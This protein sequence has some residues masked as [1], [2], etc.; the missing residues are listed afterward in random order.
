M[1]LRRPTNH[2]DA[3]VRGMLAIRALA[4]LA[5]A[6]VACGLVLS[7]SP[8]SAGAFVY[9]AS[10]RGQDRI[11]RANL[12]GTGAQTLIPTSGACAV[13]VDASHVYWATNG[14]LFRANLDGTGVQGIPGASATCGVAVDGSHIYWSRWGGVG[15]ANLDGSGVDDHFI[16]LGNGITRGVAV[17]ASH[18]YWGNTDTAQVSRA[19]IDGSHPVADFIQAT[20]GVSGVAVDAND[21]YWAN[22]WA[23]GGGGTTIGRASLNGTDVNNTFITGTWYP[24]GVAVDKDHVY[25]GSDVLVDNPTTFIGRANLD[26]TD[27]NQ[28]FIPEQG[29]CGV[30][31]DRLIPATVTLTATPAG[32]TFFGTPLNFT[33]TVTG[34]GA[35]AT[36]H[37]AFT[38]TGESP[39][40]APLSAAAAQFAPAD[41]YL[42]VGDRVAARYSGDS[43]YGPTATT[44]APDIK[45]A[46]TAVHVSASTGAPTAGQDVDV[47]ATV[48]NL[49]TLIVPFGSV[50]LDIDGYVLDSEPVDDS[51]HVTWTLTPPEAGDYSITLRYHDDTGT[52]ADFTDSSASL[53]AHVAAPTAP[54]TSPPA[55]TPTTPASPVGGAST[56]PTVTAPKPATC[57]VPKVV[58]RTLT[59]AKRILKQHRCRVGKVTHRK[60]KRSRRGRVIA[61]RPTAGHK[62]SKPV[63][64]VV[65]R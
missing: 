8:S 6:L 19:D 15:R 62:T 20:N 65:G 47:T 48:Q 54:A 7:A 1:D 17:D 38:V 11:G 58:G 46:A 30:A 4:M 32:Q 50:S 44:L 45:P 39:V 21:I 60:A 64:L 41:Y 2:E 27:T 23:G 29:T 59:A 36:G 56:Q 9:W 13:A 5:V 10:W 12:D 61:T 33:A 53:V 51:G 43:T 22:Y 26:G 49:S 25:W 37:V 31:V 52:P 3:L 28:T 55:A 34:A 18:V 16:D 24:C 63:A 40:D 57:V 14:A 42:N 35:P